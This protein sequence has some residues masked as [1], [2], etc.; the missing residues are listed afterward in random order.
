MAQHSWSQEAPSLLTEVDMAQVLPVSSE[1][2]PRSEPSQV[3]LY[4][5]LLTIL[6]T[7]RENTL[8]KLVDINV[9]LLCYNISLNYTI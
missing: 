3:K 5:V 9:N 2:S 7:S 1:S 6:K 4:I 8:A